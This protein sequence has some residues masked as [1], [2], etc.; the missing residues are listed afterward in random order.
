MHPR[1]VR[2][3]KTARFTQVVA[4]AGKP[5]V[6]LLL[7]DP[8]QDREFQSALKSNRILTIHQQNVGTKKDVGTVGYEQDGPA[9]VLVFPKSISQFSGAK[10]VGINY[11]LLEKEIRTPEPRNRRSPKGRVSSPPK[12]HPKTHAAPKKE[13]EEEKLAETPKPAAKAKARPKKKVPAKK[14]EAS[15]TIFR[16]EEERDEEPAAE[17]PSRECSR[18]QLIAGIHRALKALDEGKQVAAYKTLEQLL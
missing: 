7:M 8:K 3:V 13:P 5:K 15:I 9:Q 18:E 1:E 6:H 11:E 2:Q 12:P 4:A 10:I 16:P 17:P 14:D